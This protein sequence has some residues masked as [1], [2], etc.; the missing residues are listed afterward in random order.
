LS[1]EK[2]MVILWYPPHLNTYTA[3]CSRDPLP[4]P[5]HAELVHQKLI[6]AVFLKNADNKITLQS[7]R[8]SRK[9]KVGAGFHM[10]E[11]DLF[12]GRQSVFVQ[13]G[14]HAFVGIGEMQVTSTPRDIWNYNLYVLRVQ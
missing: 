13:T 7:G 8:E 6:A 3:P 1:D 11:M 2:E 9:F 10:V 14:N 5:A 4:C 12:P